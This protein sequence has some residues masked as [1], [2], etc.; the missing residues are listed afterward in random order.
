MY[1]CPANTFQE[2]NVQ[3]HMMQSQ[4]HKPRS[5]QSPQLKC[6]RPLEGALSS[7]CK[8]FLAPDDRAGEFWDFLAG[9]TDSTAHVYQVGRVA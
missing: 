4:K 9:W 8:S 1:E 5:I 2:R 7:N 3:I 6:S